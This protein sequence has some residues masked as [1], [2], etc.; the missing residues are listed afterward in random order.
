MPCWPSAGRRAK[1][2][3]DGSGAVILGLIRLSWL[4]KE[5]ERGLKRGS[6]DY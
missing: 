3:R 4:V 2:G 5:G 1:V 6:F